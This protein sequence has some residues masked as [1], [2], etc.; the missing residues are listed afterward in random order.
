M[1]LL[2]KTYTMIVFLG[3]IVEKDMMIMTMMI[4]AKEDHYNAFDEMI[5][6]M[7]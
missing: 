4:M 6:E 5:D 3:I 1:G 2:L 7:I